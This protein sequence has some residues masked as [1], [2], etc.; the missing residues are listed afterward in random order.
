MS[1]LNQR[2]VESIFRELVALDASTRHQMLKTI[3]SA[4]RLE[5]EQLLKLDAEADAQGLL[6]S[7]QPPDNFGARFA[8]GTLLADRYRI[9]SLIGQGGMG[10]VY[11]ADDLQLG[12]TVALKFQPKRVETDEDRGREA[13]Q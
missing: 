7:L 8:A 1:K 13:G 2:S 4:T 3:D 11:R 9:V 5:V 12:I 6:Q 10:E